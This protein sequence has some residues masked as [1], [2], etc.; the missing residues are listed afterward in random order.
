L[1]LSGAN[2]R[3]PNGVPQAQTH[4]WVRAACE[5]WDEIGLQRLRIKREQL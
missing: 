5:T 4:G 1:A 3:S 2:A